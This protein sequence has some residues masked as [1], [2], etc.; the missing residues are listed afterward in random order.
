MR[1][2]HLVPPVAML[3]LIVT[4]CT[5][6]SRGEPTPAPTTETSAAAPPSTSTGDD[7]DVPS[8][9]A[10][11]VDEP[12]EET[13]RYEQDPCSMLTTGQARELNLPTTGEPDEIPYGVG[14][15]W[16]NTD[17]RG[18]VMI[19]L[20]TDNDRGLSAV[21]AA[22]Q[23]G[24]LAYF[25]PLADIDGHPAVASDVEDRRSTGICIVDVGLTDQLLMGIALN[26]SQANV[27]QK[28]PCE[29]AADVAGMALQTM[30][31]GA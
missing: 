27:G 8:H 25:V 10:P 6:M 5:T 4:G 12:F 31:D 28:D 26:L 21:Y 29:V 19:S 13:A 15:K 2:R 20:L 16:R 14:C 3:C 9:G 17:T 30:K 7:G 11:K 24:D 22:D 18:Q 23:R 1:I